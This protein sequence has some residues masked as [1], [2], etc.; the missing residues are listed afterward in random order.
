MA[1]DNVWGV[2]HSDEPTANDHPTRQ[3]LSALRQRCFQTQQAAAFIRLC[4]GLLRLDD[5]KQL[6]SAFCNNNNF[7]EG[8]GSLLNY[9]FSVKHE[10]NSFNW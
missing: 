2:T 6:L 4:N 5:K 10:W 1:M 8:S 7:R 3:F 9:T